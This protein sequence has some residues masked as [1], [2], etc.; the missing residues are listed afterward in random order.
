LL[1]EKALGFCW[2][3][4]CITAPHPTSKVKEG[5]GY[6]M[7]LKDDKQLQNSY[8]SVTPQAECRVCSSDMS[9]P[10]YL[11]VV[12]FRSIVLETSFNAV[13]SF[14]DRAGSQDLLLRMLTSVLLRTVNLRHY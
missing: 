12:V 2:D 7:V 11:L 10:A 14:L 1:D 4:G 9:I 5:R 6:V 3:M 8:S 13:S